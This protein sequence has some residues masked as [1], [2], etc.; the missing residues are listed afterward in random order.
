MKDS[1]LIVIKVCLIVLA[2]VCLSGCSKSGEKKTKD[3]VDSNKKEEVSKTEEQFKTEEQ[4]KKEKQLKKEELQ[5][6]Y[7]DKKLITWVY[8]DVVTITREV[9]LAINQELQKENYEFVLY[10]EQIEEK[11]YETTLNR[12]IA[13]GNSPDIISASVGEMGTLQGT[14]RA[15]ENKWLLNLNEYLKTMEGQELSS[16]FPEKQLKTCQVNGTYYGIASFMPITT[17]Y[18]YYVNQQLMDKYEISE[19]ELSARSVS[20]LGEILEKVNDKEKNCTLLTLR[21][22]ESWAG[23]LDGYSTVVEPQGNQTDAIVIDYRDSSGNA[24]SIFEEESA[25]Q[26]FHAVAT[27]KQKGYLRKGDSFFLVVDRNNQ[28]SN[29]KETKLQQL[30]NEYPSVKE[31][32]AID[33]MKTSVDSQYNSITGVCATTQYKELALQALKLSVTN[34]KISDLLLYGM[35]GTDYVLED[36]VVVGEDFGWLYAMYFGNRFIST[37]TRE[38]MSLDKEKWTE[39]INEMYESPMVGVYFNLQNYNKEIE[40]IQNI[41]IQ[42]RGLLTGEYQEVDQVLEELN[43]KLKENGLQLVIDEINKQRDQVVIGE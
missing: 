11:N 18:T 13:D 34:Q 41:L 6:M 16:A 32:V 29:Y 15:Y 7:P 25:V 36:G 39:R 21:T 28:F 43:K 5:A 38:E 22:A 12:R 8:N 14:Y 1:N 4:L 26:W 9:N 20:E 10:F 17:N 2:F 3:H 31:V 27:Y 24:V 23:Y 40:A 35:E 42:Y 37:K 33:Y 19:E 30:A